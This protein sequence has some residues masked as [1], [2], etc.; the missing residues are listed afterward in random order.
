MFLELSNQ[1]VRLVFQ[2]RLERISSSEDNRIKANI[3]NALCHKGG[4]LRQ[5]TMRN[6]LLVSC[7][8]ETVLTCDVTR[9][10]YK[11]EE[12]SHHFLSMS[13]KTRHSLGGRPG[14][15]GGSLSTRLTRGSR[16]LSR[17]SNT[18]RL[19]G[20]VRWLLLRRFFHDQSPF[21]SSFEKDSQR[22]SIQ[23]IPLNL[24]WSRDY[25]T[26]ILPS[27]ICCGLL[28]GSLAE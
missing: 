17:E 9:T 19:Q 11:K 7:R 21:S 5:N 23:K 2:T 20:M 26:Q 14:L 18:T 16:T 22:S 13:E 1:L 8:V 28:F 15:W 12:G 25:F 27:P 3:S 4:V 6:P 24:N 10:V